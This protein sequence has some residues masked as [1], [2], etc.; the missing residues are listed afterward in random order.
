MK[1]LFRAKI[2]GLLAPDVA[3]GQTREI[4]SD[5][6]NLEAGKRKPRPSGRGNLFS[7]DFRSC[8]VLI[9]LI[10]AFFIPNL[11]KSKIPLPADA[12]LGLYHPFRDI[13]VGGYNQAKFPVK[14]PLI[15]DPVL[16]T[17]PWRLITINNIKEGKLPLWNPYS[18]S[19]GPLLANIQSATFQLTNILFLF[20]NFK[21]AWAIL[22]ILS[23]VLG[24]IFMFL[25]LREL[26][27][28]RIASTFG[29]FIFPFCGFFIAWF[30]WGTITTS[31]VWL[32]LILLA[33]VKIYKNK[34]II[35]FPI[36]ALS[37]SQTI[38]SGHFQTA[39]YVLA[40]SILY[41]IFLLASSKKIIQF[42]IC[43]LAI[44]LGTIISSIQ[45]LPSL[46]FIKYSA[47][48]LDQQYWAAR[49]DWFLPTK[50]LIQFIVPDYFG[51]PSTNNYWGIW[52]YGEFIGFIGIVPLTFAIYAAL[53]K[54]RQVLFYIFL[55]MSSL[56]IGLGTPLAKIPYVVNIPLISSIQPSRIIFLITFSLI[57]LSAFGFDAFLKKK[58]KKI[59]IAP[60]III[61]SLLIL[62]TITYSQTNL[63]S[64]T[65]GASS[66]SIALRNL[67]IP[68]FTVIILII[69]LAF[70][71][72]IPAK[73]LIF[74][75][76]A[77]TTFEL[78]RFGYK[79][80]SFTDIN[81]I[82]PETK[83]I[84]F[85]KNQSKPFR[86]MATD[87][88]ILPPNSSSAYEIES[89][90]GYDPLYLKDYGQ[91]VSIWQSGNPQ[92]I[93]GS[94]N[95]IITPQ[96]YST[97]IVNLLNVKY[98]LT[99]DEIYKEGFVKVLEE[100]QTKLFINNNSLPRAFFVKEVLKNASRTDEFRKLISPDFDFA[101]LATSVDFEF[102][103]SIL[104]SSVEFLNY[105][106]SDF[107]LIT[108]SDKRAPLLVS[109][110]NYPGWQLTIDGQKS[111]IYSAN[112][113]FQLA[114]VP[115]GEHLLEFKFRP[116][117]FYNGLYL[118]TAAVVATTLATTYLWRK[119]SL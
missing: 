109:N 98:V 101:S 22:I 27:I 119:K 57:I 75:L 4:L 112:T 56:T 23:E 64:Q 12:L 41:A 49:A 86:V 79:F 40:A 62:A 107:A 91:F 25:F 116:K 10:L 60:L 17:F 42:L 48:N 39:F 74:L 82:F 9:L 50:H 103:E 95:R 81:L 36:L 24:G 104:N 13:D 61:G 15:T 102:K 35:S 45:I 7:K 118:S 83:I 33:I 78:F 96:N 26:K 59:F 38:L 5:V 54:N 68:A 93:S 73:I 11:I 66:Q 117:S 32:P 31:A 77:T 43:L 47:R 20:L 99:F 58:N 37:T 51:N 84:T 69:I 6:A 70:S 87:R 92:A 113:I 108:K 3:S 114:I 106:D 80:T 1:K 2:S 65:G 71:T 94:F 46:E 63:F 18:F 85:L 34:P 55:L 89:V 29:G 19:G 28:S 90:E 115:E 30:S 76:F 8:L 16:Q 44:S 97:N 67:V 105:S 21:I 52:N 72:K 111:P 88:R 100:G 110:I 14:N 53:I